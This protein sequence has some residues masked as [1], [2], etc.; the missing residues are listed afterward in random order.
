MQRIISHIE[1][2]LDKHECVIIPGFGA[3]INR[4]QPAVIDVINHTIK[5]PCRVLS[6]NAELTH[7]DGLLASSYA[8]ALSIPYTTATS[9]ISND[10]ELIKSNIG[11][12]GEVQFGSI[13][14]ITVGA[15]SRLIFSQELSTFATTGLSNIQLE[16]EHQEEKNKTAAVLPAPQRYNKTLHRIMRYAAMLVILFGVGI[17]LST[18]L[19]S[20][21]DDAAVMQASLCPIQ[22][23][24]PDPIIEQEII[25]EFLIAEPK[26]QEPVPATVS[27]HDNYCLVI[28]S[29][30]T[31]DQANQFIAEAGSD[32]IGMFEYNGRYRVYATTGPDAASVRDEQIESRYIGAW[33]CAMPRE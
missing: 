16:P 25:P 32:A 9:L 33:P 5:A 4:Y 7:D 18:P 13:G 14:R 19:V 12:A 1:Y 15:D 30:A 31:L 23:A 26:E 24:A 8:R 17:I 20:I 28:A 3:F 27:T 10:V 6:F 22:T 11:N 2:L 29:L 21:T